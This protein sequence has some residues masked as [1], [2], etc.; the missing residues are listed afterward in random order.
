V[1]CPVPLADLWWRWDPSWR[2]TDVSW[3]PS[4][5]CSPHSPCPVWYACSAVSRPSGRASCTSEGGVLKAGNKDREES[6]MRSPYF[7]NITFLILKNRAV[8]LYCTCFWD[9]LEGLKGLTILVLK[10]IF[11]PGSNFFSCSWLKKVLIL[12]GSNT[13][14]PRYTVLR[15]TVHP[16]MPGLFLQNIFPRIFFCT[17]QPGH[18]RGVVEPY[19]LW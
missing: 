2:C 13:V 7:D 4:A 11:L 17:W 15:Y 6:R 12:S 3:T 19:I 14:R 18:I 5:P 10:I 16:D 8:E 1:A 9:T